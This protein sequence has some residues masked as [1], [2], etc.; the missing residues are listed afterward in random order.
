M[1]LSITFCDLFPGKHFGY[2]IEEQNLDGFQNNQPNR[3][4]CFSAF[5][6]FLD[7]FQNENVGK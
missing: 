5:F 6:F 7:T 4:T 1:L 2:D 3:E